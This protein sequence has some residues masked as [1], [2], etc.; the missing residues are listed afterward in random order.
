M[1]ARDPRLQRTHVRSPLS[2]KPLSGTGIIRQIVRS[3]LRP[4]RALIAV[5]ASVF[6]ACTGA[7][8]PAHLPAAQ[9]L[10]VRNSVSAFVTAVA[11]G[12]TRRGPAAWRTF[13]SDTPEF[14]MASEGQLVFA[15]GDAA[16]RGIDELTRVITQ[17]ELRWGEPV[18]IQP[19]TS[20]L[21]IVGAPYHELR[22]DSAG[23]RVEENGYF[24]GLAELGPT[25]WRFSNAHWSV[26]TGPSAVP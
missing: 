22:L 11:E 10:A 24:T 4:L 13:F 14:F 8:T 6:V 25:G 7:M 26:A 9:A 16:T 19:L 23:H 18:R 3:S 5:T 17:I 21:A 20:T 2:R 15:S 1:N 12:V